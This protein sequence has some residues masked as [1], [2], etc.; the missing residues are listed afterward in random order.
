MY[1]LKL[2]TIY[3]IEKFKKAI[4]NLD[5]YNIKRYENYD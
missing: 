1:F 5:K 2:K 4:S 3:L